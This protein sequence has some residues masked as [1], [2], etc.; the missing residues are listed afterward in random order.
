MCYT[1]AKF[2]REAPGDGVIVYPNPLSGATFR[3]I[4]FRAALDLEIAHPGDDAF[5]LEQ[6]RVGRQ[7]ANVQDIA[8]VVLSLRIRG[9]DG[10]VLGLK[11]EVGADC[12]HVHTGTF[13][14][15]DGFF[16]SA[17]NRFVLVKA[18]VQ[19][20]RNSRPALKRTD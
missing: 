20:H 4:P 13:E 6:R 1:K 19:N 2:S 10:S 15:V 7:M 16:R 14:A 11:S 8:H 9:G 17:D 12:Q 18:G 5:V 3:G